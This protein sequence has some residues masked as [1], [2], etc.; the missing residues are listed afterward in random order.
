MADTLIIGA[1]V[2]GMMSALELAAKGDRV[3]LLDVGRHRPPASWAGGGILSPLFPWRY[4]DPL[5]ALASEALPLYRQW[6]AAILAAG[7]P[8]P[9]I[10]QDGMLVFARDG[11][12][13][14]AW[15][16]RHDVELGARTQCGFEPSRGGEALWLANIATV[17]N[18]LLLRGLRILL[19]RS[20]VPLL[21]TR[22]TDIRLGAQGVT[23]MAGDGALHADRVL[24][25][26]GAWSSP[27]L[28]SWMRADIF[29][30]RG[31]MLLYR[32]AEPLACV[33]LDDAG[34]LIPRRDGLVL[35]GSTLEL[36]VEDTVPTAAAH[37]Q[38]RSMAE[39]LWPALRRAELRAQWAG[40]RPGSQRALPLIGEV[41]GTDGRLWL[42]GG[43]FRN[44]LVCAPASARLISALMCGEAAACDPTPYAL[45]PSS[46]ASS[47]SP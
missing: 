19:A 35:A 10:R 20:G 16:W 36:E 4:P 18:P 6:Q 30:V 40:L 27:L 43:H 33:V 31:Q 2:A 32:S 11:A 25:T 41:P 14:R 34:Y 1:G 37:Q 26:A 3:R 21:E 24:V 45:S 28:A 39:R 29:P 9:E 13:A 23:V 8:D 15:A 12:R 7:G 22:A 17:R 42:N 47:L 46:S 5:H 44:G 38:L